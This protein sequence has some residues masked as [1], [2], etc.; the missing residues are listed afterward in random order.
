MG[1]WLCSQTS[2]TEVTAYI[3]GSVVSG[4]K[5]QGQ[6]SN[7]QWYECIHGVRNNV[8]K[9][10]KALKQWALPFYYY[11]PQQTAKAGERPLGSS[12]RALLAV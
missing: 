9:M 3:L 7:F 10:M 2:T 5:L 1:I 8:G 6:S 11:S 4:D 12:P